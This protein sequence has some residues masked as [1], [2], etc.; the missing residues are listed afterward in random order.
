MKIVKKIQMKIV[1]FTAVKN[2]CMLHGRVFVMTSATD[3]DFSSSQQNNLISDF[4]FLEK[5]LLT[6]YI[7]NR[8]RKVKLTS[9]AELRKLISGSHVLCLRT[10]II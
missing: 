10:Y 6:V 5:P 1:I 8:L 2:R 4:Y 7:I 3:K 9:P